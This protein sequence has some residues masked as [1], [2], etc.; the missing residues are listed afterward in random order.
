M[1]QILLIGLAIWLTIEGVTYVT[2]A[3]TRGWNWP[4]RYFRAFIQNVRGQ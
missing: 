2:V 1:P 4:V 3:R